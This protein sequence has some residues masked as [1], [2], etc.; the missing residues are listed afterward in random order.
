MDDGVLLARCGADGL[1]EAGEVTR[2]VGFDLEPERARVGDGVDHAAI[3]DVDRYRTLAREF[4][5]RF[6]F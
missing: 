6:E 2:F 4:E 5:R 1:A 3:G